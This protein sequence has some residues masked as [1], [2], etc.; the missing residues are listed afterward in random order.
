VIPFSFSDLAAASTRI[1][2]GRASRTRCFDETLD[3]PV[4]KTLMRKAVAQFVCLT[5]TG[6]HGLLVALQALILLPP[7]CNP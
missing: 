1:A 6:M 3:E 5:A 7:L 4:V 2:L